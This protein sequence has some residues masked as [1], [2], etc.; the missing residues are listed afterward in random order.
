MTKSLL[1]AAALM[2]SALPATA[3]TAAEQLQRGIF[4]QDSQGNVD[5]AI[6][7]YRQFPP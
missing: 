5:A 3:Q 4:T 7:I 2:M 6:T 1:L